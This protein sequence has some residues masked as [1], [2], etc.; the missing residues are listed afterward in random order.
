MTETFPEPLHDVSNTCSQQ[1]TESTYDELKEEVR[2]SVYAT[3]LPCMPRNVLLCIVAICTMSK[4]ACGHLYLCLD[5]CH[6]MQVKFREVAHDA[7]CKAYAKLA[8]LS[9][10]DI[11]T[12]KGIHH[13]VKVLQVQTGP[14][15]SCCL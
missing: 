9:A 13:R 10:S 12:A 5:Q 6:G 2:P 11:N 4:T 14:T 7:L 3:M 1:R 15:L 8:K